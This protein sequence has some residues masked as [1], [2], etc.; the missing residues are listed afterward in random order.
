MT[1]A[2]RAVIDLAALRHNLQ[3]AQTA[4]PHS[5]QFAIIK[6]NGYGH[7][8][9][10]VA[11]AL[12][13]LLAQD[14]GFGVASLEEALLL[15]NA[16]ITQPILLLEGF[17]QADEL[18]A[19][20]Q[21]RL[22]IVVHHQDHVAQLEQ[23]GAS[24]EPITTWLKVD[25]GMRRLGFLPSEA[26]AIWQRL[27]NC[28]ATSPRC[29]MTH[30]ACADDLHAASAQQQIE[31]FQALMPKQEMDRSIANSAGI[32][33]WLGSHAD[34]VRPGILLFGASPFVDE[35]GEARRLRP[36]MSLQSEIIAIKPCRQGDT[37]GYGGDWTCP[38]D[39]P[40]GI[41]AIGYGDGYPRHAPSGTPVLV[42]GKRV[43]LVGRV[44]MDMLC[45]DLR[46]QPHTKVGD[47]VLLWGPDLSAEDVARSAGTIAYE[48]FCGITERVPRHYVNEGVS[49][50]IPHG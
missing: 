25:T 3:R 5:R 1:R 50:E 14:S 45:V 43:P 48:L 2:A 36:V 35:S 11:Q 49:R 4:A 32:L 47:P 30:L 13:P 22:D 7:G 46:E 27:Q 20:R 19:I 40:L 10:P 8:L 15:R 12:A 26:P 41:V 16:N 18:A 9:V 38:T 39:L 24:A 37:V 28:A 44:S 42:N 21:H 33:G 34:V 23:L 31:T 17:F 6:A 29:L